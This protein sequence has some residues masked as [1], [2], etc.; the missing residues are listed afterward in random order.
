MTRKLSI[1]YKILVSLSLFIGITLNLFETS[2][3]IQLLSYYTFQSNIICFLAFITYLMIECLDKNRSY[4]KNDIYHLTKGSIVIMIL[5][6][7]SC[8]YIALLPFGFNME[9]LQQD[10]ATRKIANFFV[11]TF[12]PFLVI[13]DYFL[14]DEKG[15]FKG[16][17]PFLW[18]FFPINYVLYVYFYS[19]KG[20][21]FYGIGGSDKFAYFFLD[22]TQLGIS[23]VIKWVTGIIFVIL[24][25]SYILVYI[26]KIFKLKRKEKK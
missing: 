22:Y 11:H 13:L 5:I 20:G 21:T 17:Y 26:D 10:L 6:T 7:I 24:L 8:Y 18:L 1:I 12:S 3:P 9:S 19:S 23:G 2:A 25:V 4:Q 16:Y 15:N 14:F